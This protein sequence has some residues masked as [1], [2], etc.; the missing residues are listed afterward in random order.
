VRSRYVL[1]TVLDRI[2]LAVLCCFLVVSCKDAGDRVLPSE[3]APPPSLQ[4]LF[5]NVF[6]QADEGVVGIEAID[7]NS[8]IGIY[9]GAGWCPACANFTPLL[10]SFY[11][12][13]EEAGES[14]EIVF[15]SFD[16]SEDDMFAHMTDRGMPWLA[17]PLGGD[18]AD[19]LTL[20]YD[21]TGIPT[22]V[23]IDAEANTVTVTGRADVVTKGALAYDDWFAN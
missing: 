21:V 17:V 5:G 20:R 19:A 18:K 12:E 14:F 16:G 3:P 4:D 11:D 1:Q 6:Y 7:Q 8:I 23:V 15:V 22:L 13:L 2:V 10:V 9:F